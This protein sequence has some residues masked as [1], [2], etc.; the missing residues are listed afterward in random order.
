MLIHA[1]TG[2]FLLFCLLLLIIALAEDILQRRNRETW[3]KGLHYA[4]LVLGLS[5]LG[6]AFIQLIYAAEEMLGR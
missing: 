2:P 3:A 1:D 6:R 5:L 4:V